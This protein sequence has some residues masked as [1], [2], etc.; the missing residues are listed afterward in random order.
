MFAG[1]AADDAQA[2]SR[3]DPTAPVGSQRTVKRR[4]S[5]RHTLANGVDFNMVSHLHM[6]GI[7]HSKNMNY[8]FKTC[9]NFVIILKLTFSLTHPRHSI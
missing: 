1:I 4:D 2:K 3:G 8:S 7:Y 5:R 6:Y 9:K